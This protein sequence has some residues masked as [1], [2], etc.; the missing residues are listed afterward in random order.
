MDK[1]IA[2]Q[3]CLSLVVIYGLANVAYTELSGRGL[4]SL[5]KTTRY[6]GEN[7]KILNPAA[8]SNTPKVVY[9]NVKRVLHPKRN[10]FKYFTAQNGTWVETCV[11]NDDTP[12]DYS[13]K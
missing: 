6:H 5:I 3:V 2:L 7:G 13:E 8:D 11:P 12:K 4:R 10:C 9:L 1:T